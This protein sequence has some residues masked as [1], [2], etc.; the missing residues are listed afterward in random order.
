MARPARSQNAPASPAPAR[1]GPYQSEREAAVAVR[2]IHAAAPGIALAAGNH[3]MLTQACAAARVQ[4]GDWDRRVL[5]WLAGWEPSTC[6]VVA[7]LICRAAAAPSPS[8]PA[9]R[10]KVPDGPGHA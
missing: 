2:A 4:L 1:C 6:A 10:K 8:P 3:Q 7:G 5:T 9:G